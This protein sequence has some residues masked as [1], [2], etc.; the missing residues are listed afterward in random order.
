VLKHPQ[1]A[2]EKRAALPIRKGSA[3]RTGDMFALY[4]KCLEAVIGS[5]I[6]GLTTKH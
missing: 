3:P 2:L 5:G 1:E 6:M 4:K